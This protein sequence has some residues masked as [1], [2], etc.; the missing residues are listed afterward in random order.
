MDPFFLCLQPQS[1]DNQVIPS[2]HRICVADASEAWTPGTARAP[3]PFPPPAHKP[4]S[5]KHPFHLTTAA[6]SFERARAPCRPRMPRRGASINSTT[7]RRNGGISCSR[8]MV[9]MKMGG[10]MTTAM[11]AASLSKLQRES[12]KQILRRGKGKSC[13]TLHSYGLL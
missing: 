3:I 6:L 4:P 9:R 8:T 13:G 10:A 11:Q 5:P 7:G 2:R 1:Q 12:W